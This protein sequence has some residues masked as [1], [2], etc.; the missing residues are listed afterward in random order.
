MN[1]AE[2]GA[3]ALLA[4][5][6]NELEESKKKVATQPGDARRDAGA[7]G[8]EHRLEQAER[9]IE[10]LTD[11]RRQLRL[12]GEQSHRW[13]AA[14]KRSAKR[15][16]TGYLTEL[17]RHE[18]TAQQLQEAMGEF[19]RL[20][21]RALSLPSDAIDAYAEFRENLGLSSR[22]SKMRALRDLRRSSTQ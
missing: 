16:R 8:L 5:V 6:L 10:R 22:A 9:R 20:Q 1:E 3:I 18:R 11:E 2:I 13:A 21:D 7:G 19:M 4:T 15:R 14:W 12:I 17:S